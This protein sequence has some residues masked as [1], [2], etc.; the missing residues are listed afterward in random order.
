M[1]VK[2]LV[3]LRVC[4]G[5]FLECYLGDNYIGKIVE[6]YIGICYFRLNRWRNDNILY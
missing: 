3:R 4:N 1:V 6:G 2:V 5:D